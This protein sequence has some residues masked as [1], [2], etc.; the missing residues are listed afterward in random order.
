MA[1]F[2]IF[3]TVKERSASSSWNIN[4]YNAY[5]YFGIYCIHHMIKT[6]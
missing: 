2:Q 4:V 1:R 6:C 5:I 3:L